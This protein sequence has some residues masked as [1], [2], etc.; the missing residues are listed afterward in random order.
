MVLFTTAPLQT[1]E[2]NR[3]SPTKTTFPNHLIV[4]YSNLL[5]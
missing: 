3:L 4:A 2:Q 5:A 1:L